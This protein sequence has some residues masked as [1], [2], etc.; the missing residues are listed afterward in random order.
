MPTK[1][2]VDVLTFL[3]PGFIAAALVFSLTPAPRPIPFERVIQALIF[4]II[5]QVCVNGTRAVLLWAGS[6]RV[7]LGA[8]SD[9]VAL[10][11]SVA[12]AVFLGLFFVWASNTDKIHAFLRRTGITH[13]TSFASE[14]YGALS[15]NRGYVVLHLK[16]ERR[17]F[18]W[19]EEWPSTADA[20]HFVVAQAEWLG[21]DGA[22]TE[23]RGVQRILVKAQD[24]EMIELMEPTTGQENEHG[25]S[26]GTDAAPS[27]QT[28]E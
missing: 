17:L 27:T 2:I 20:G 23:L 3:L 12:F 13:Q 5:I 22:R 14:W 9:N 11:W 25:R 18:G 15:Q 4:T 8:W 6:H 21:D 26:Q 16:G 19:P 1:A 7:A 24:V 10:V 28:L